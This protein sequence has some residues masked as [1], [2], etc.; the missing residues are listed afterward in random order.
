MNRR[1][2]IVDLKGELCKQGRIPEVDKKKAVENLK[3]LMLIS[4]SFHGPQ[5]QDCRH[6][7]GTL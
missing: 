2:G 5:T 6:E 4:T 3:D 1:L 7:R